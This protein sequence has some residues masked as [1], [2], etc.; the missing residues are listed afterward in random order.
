MSFIRSRPLLSLLFINLDYLFLFTPPILTINQEEDRYFLPDTVSTHTS[1]SIIHLQPKPIRQQSISLSRTY[2]LSF[3]FSLRTPIFA[4]R[5]ERRTFKPLSKNLSSVIVR[6]SS[7]V[8]LERAYVRTFRLLVRRPFS[9]RVECA[10]FFDAFVRI[11]FNASASPF[12]R[13]IGRRAFDDTVKCGRSV[14]RLGPIIADSVL[15]S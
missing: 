10:R 8:C 13:L 6:R 14:L 1:T 4:D 5:E 15:V 11:I 9:G 3:S 12:V 7:A 2:T